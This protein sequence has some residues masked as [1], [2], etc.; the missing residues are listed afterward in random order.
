MAVPPYTRFT[1]V[2]HL[3]YFQLF[4]KSTLLRYNI[5]IIKCTYLKCAVQWVL[6]NISSYFR[7]RCYEHARA[8]LWWAFVSLGCV[9]WGGLL[10][11]R[12]HGQFSK[13]AETIYAPT[14]SEWEVQLLLGVS[15][16]SVTAFC[17]GGGTEGRGHPTALFICFPSPSGHPNGIH[18]TMLQS[19]PSHWVECP[20]VS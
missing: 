2:G 1:I 9:L 17:G 12:V 15:V 4:F 20:S 11:H 14:S 3:D 8:G 6:T 18:H 13:V 16:L 7:H 5:H 19:R 10:R